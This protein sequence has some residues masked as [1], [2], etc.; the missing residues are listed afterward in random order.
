MRRGRR[1]TVGISRLGGT[2]EIA[3]VAQHAARKV[4]SPD[5]EDRPRTPPSAAASS[6]REEPKPSAATRAIGTLCGP[7]RSGAP[8]PGQAAHPA[9]DTTTPSHCTAL[10]HSPFARS[11]PESD[12]AGGGMARL[13]HGADRH[14]PIERGEPDRSHAPSLSRERHRRR[15]SRPRTPLT[16]RAP[17]RPAPASCTT[18]KRESAGARPAEEVND[19]QAPPPDRSRPPMRLVADWPGGC[20]FVELVRWYSTAARGACSVACGVPR[21]HES[22]VRRSARGD[23][24]L[25]DET[26]AEWTWPSRTP[27]RRAYEGLARALARGRRRGARGPEKEVRTQPGERAVSRHTS[28]PRRVLEQTARLPVMAVRPAAGAGASRRDLARPRTWRR[29]LSGRSRSRREE[30]EK[31]SSSSGR[32]ASS[33]PAGSGSTS[34]RLP[35]A[36]EPAGDRRSAHAPDDRTRRPRERLS[37]ISTSPTRYLDPPVGSTSSREVRPAL[38][39]RASV[40]GDRIPRRRCDPRRA[41]DRRTDGLARVCSRRGRRSLV[42]RRPL[43]QRARA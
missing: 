22:S 14:A 15:P 28:R 38:G 27:S 43:R 13:S 4:T 26:H 34:A 21:R 29:G 11:T 33:S 32:D 10:G 41:R 40:A 23:R 30:L 19:T 17:T 7:A 9:E 2:T 5:R 31:P 25:V 12:R 42:S 1:D 20:L 3:S 6:P 8:A 35:L 39:S 36:P 16:G 37:R 24:A 18:V